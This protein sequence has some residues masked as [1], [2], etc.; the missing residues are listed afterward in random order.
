M[1]KPTLQAFLAELKDC[2]GDEAIDL[3]TGYQDGSLV[4]KGTK[5]E[6]QFQLSRA[7]TGDT[8]VRVRVLIDG[9][10]TKQDSFIWS[11]GDKYQWKTLVLTRRI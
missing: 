5:I 6:V 10:L 9:V 8:N 2:S 1:R 7:V 3:I 11:A 4:I